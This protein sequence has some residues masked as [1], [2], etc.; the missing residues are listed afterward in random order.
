MA[1]ARGRLTLAA[2]AGPPSPLNPA[3]PVPATRVMVG[4]DPKAV[5]VRATAAVSA[6]TSAQQHRFNWRI[7]R[8]AIWSFAKYLGVSDQFGPPFANP[9]RWPVFSKSPWPKR[10]KG[11]ILRRG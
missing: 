8:R 10:E 4:V 6:T 7:R 11:H 5:P 1:T 2:R 3:V 9:A